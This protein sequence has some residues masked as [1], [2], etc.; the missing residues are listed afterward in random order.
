VSHISFDGL[1][2]ATYCPPPTNPGEKY[3][4]DG[5]APTFLAYVDCQAGIE[6]AMHGAL[7][8]GTGSHSYHSC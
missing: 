1:A 8:L 2:E 5:E 3:D 7:A 4:R 6:V